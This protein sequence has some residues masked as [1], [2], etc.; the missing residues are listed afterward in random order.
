MPIDF[1]RWPADL[2]AFLRT[3]TLGRSIVLLLGAA[4]ALLMAAN[5]ATFLMVSRTESFNRSV[6]HTQEV[7]LTAQRV[8]TL[9]VDAETG[10]RGYLLTGR[11]PY[12][13]VYNE[14]LRELPEEMDRLERLVADNP[15]QTEKARRIRYIVDERMLTLRRGVEL[16]ATGRIGEAVSLIRTG[17]GKILMDAM[18]AEVDAIGDHERRLLLARQAA[19]ERSALATL[20]INGLAGVLIII[21]AGVSIWLVRRYLADVQAARAALDQANAGLEE[22]VRTRTAELVRAN[23]EIQRFAY[24]VSH[25]LRAPLVNVMGYTSELDQAGK[26]LEGQI[27]RLEEAAPDLV[28]ADARTAV[29][30]DVPEAIGFIR[31]STAKMDRLINAILKLSREGRRT[32]TPETL[33]MRKLAQGIADSVRHQTDAADAEIEVGDLP[34]VESDRLSM[35]QVFGNLI[36]NAVKYLDPSRPG[37]IRVTGRDAPGGWVVYEIADNGRGVPAKDHERI[38]ELFR[39]SGRQDR[40]GEGLGLA[41]VRNSVRRLG[42]VVELESEL[43][44]GSTFR[45]KF[46]KRLVVQDPG[47]AA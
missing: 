40:P 1:R 13:A 20:V 16:A 5:V 21:L 43:G 26:A 36:D 4:L 28:D 24:I 44:Q 32:L 29:R 47:D 25:D 11:G 33:D 19:S 17:R 9:A 2:A 38:F 41:F 18:R 22:T 27:R 14:A 6:E 3:P 12:L 30:E 8:L 10:Q 35:E 45:L 37:L 31:A 7:R 42:G 15:E 46:P 39:R 34:E 23:E